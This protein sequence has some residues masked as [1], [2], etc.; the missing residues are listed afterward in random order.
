MWTFTRILCIPYSYEQQSNYVCV[1]LSDSAENT[2]YFLQEE[3][4]VRLRLNI[5]PVWLLECLL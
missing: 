2:Y 1:L 4:S 3:H 5:L